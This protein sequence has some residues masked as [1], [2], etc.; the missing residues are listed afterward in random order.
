MKLKD[1]KHFEFIVRHIA[2][3]VYAQI[4]AKYPTFVYPINMNNYSLDRDQQIDI[5]ISQLKLKLIQ[6]IANAKFKFE[7][8]R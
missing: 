8:D 5:A 6:E 4:F 2:S 3:E 1:Q 7:T